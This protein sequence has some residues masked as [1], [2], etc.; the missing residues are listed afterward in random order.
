MPADCQL[1]SGCWAPA[2]Q[3]E[4][5]CNGMHPTRPA[6]RGHRSGSTGLTIVVRG[7]AHH[8]TGT[9]H[10]QHREAVPTGMVIAA[11]DDHDRAGRAGIRARGRACRGPGWPCRQAARPPYHIRHPTA[12]HP[13]LEP[14]GP[15]RTVRC[16]QT[17]QQA[18]TP[19]QNWNFAVTCTDSYMM[20]PALSD[21]RRPVHSGPSSPLHSNDLHSL[22]L[23]Q[24]S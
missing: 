20:F 12:V 2:L 7:Q 8:V 18:L 22:R 13:W 24:I 19:C 16:Q 15:N 3:D 10:C 1:Q 11:D 14:A 21:P 9:G 17:L 5:A 23:A 4:R 6:D